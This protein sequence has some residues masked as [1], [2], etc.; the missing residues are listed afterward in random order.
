MA[1]AALPV[2]S[3]GQVVADATAPADAIG[4]LVWAAAGQV[5]Q[6]VGKQRHHQA[7]SG[8]PGP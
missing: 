8:P 4:A 3:A 6:H 1:D 5:G 7:D 2:L